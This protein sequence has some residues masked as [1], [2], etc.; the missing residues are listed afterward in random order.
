MVSY[1][2]MQG[3]TIQIHS[4]KI[5]KFKVFFFYI[6]AERCSQNFIFWAMKR[7]KSW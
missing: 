4:L 5:I 6:G 2:Y 7:L 1:L 3:N